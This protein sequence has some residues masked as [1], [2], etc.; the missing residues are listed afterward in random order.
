MHSHIIHKISVFSMWKKGMASQM[1]QGGGWVGCDRVHMMLG[2]RVLF[3]N[4]LLK[5]TLTLVILY[6]ARSCMFMHYS[7]A[8]NDMANNCHWH[9]CIIQ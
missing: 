3:W 7:H 9:T 8:L 4:V 1:C 2:Q 5:R 6:Q